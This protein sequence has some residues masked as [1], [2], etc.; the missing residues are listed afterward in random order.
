M[1]SNDYGSI[2]TCGG[3]PLD[4]G[5]PAPV[6]RMSDAQATPGPRSAAPSPP[7]QRAVETADVNYGAEQAAFLSALT[8]ALTGSSDAG[9]ATTTAYCERKGKD[10]YTY[11]QYPDGHIVVAATPTGRG[12]GTSYASGSTAAKNVEAM[13]GPCTVSASTSSS[14]SGKKSSKSS[15]DKAVAAGAFI[16]SATSELLPSLLAILGPTQVTPLDEEYTDLSTST[17]GAEEGP[18]PWLLVGGVV[19]GAGLL[20]GLIY[21]MMRKPASAAHMRLVEDEG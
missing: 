14:K 6:M 4:F 17:T 1:D 19:V 16:G 8:A 18:F 11:W 21:L 9:A 12:I 2:F 5:S 10:A 3:L 15:K 20:G 13:Y 7:E